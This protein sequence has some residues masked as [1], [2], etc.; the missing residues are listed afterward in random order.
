MYDLSSC[1]LCPRLC[2]ADR[3]QGPYG[4]CR[5]G[6]KV[7]VARAAPHLW[8]EP[9]LGGPKGSG[10]VFFGGCNLGCVFCQ[11]YAVS[12][13]PKGVPLTEE[14]L[15]QV[16]LSLQ[17]KEV[18]NINLVT[19]TPWVPQIKRALDLAWE[20]GLYLPVVYNGGG[21]ERA[22][23]LSTLRGYI[24]VYLPDFKYWDPALGKRLSGVP[25]YPDRAKEALEEMVK[26][27][28]EP[29]FDGDGLMTRGVIVRHLV[30]PEQTADAKAI[31]SYLH[32]T[33]GDSI[34]IS[35]MRQYTPMPGMKGDLARPLYEEEYEEVVGFARDLGI[36]NAFLQEGE[37]VGESFIPAFDGEGVLGGTPTAR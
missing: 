16:F 10:T 28:G 8:E 27:R 12:R 24:G 36:R 2:H 18:S 9:C 5:A 17:E 6:D 30:L 13:E 19:P 7:L 11:N 3:V 25:D 35:I 14:E 34:Y 22:E 4:F 37:A 20:E 31:L 1:T 23:V 29:R 33:Y 21:Y 15:A 26:Q 32:H